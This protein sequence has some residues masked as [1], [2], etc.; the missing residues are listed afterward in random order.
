MKGYQKNME[1]Q[2][3]LIFFIGM[4]L[5]LKLLIVAGVP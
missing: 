2:F 4:I 5:I 3:I 1:N